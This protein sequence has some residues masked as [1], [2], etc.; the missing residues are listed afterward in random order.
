MT[1]FLD[2]D[3]VLHREPCLGENAFYRL[4][5]IEQILQDFPQV[6]IVVTSAW[7]LDWTTEA[8]AVAGLREHFSPS[9]RDRLVGATPDFREVDP[10]TAPDGLGAYLREWECMD[11]LRKNRPAGTPYL[12]LDNRHWWFRPN[13]PHLM[14]VDGDDGFLPENESEFRARLKASAGK[15]TNPQNTST[16]GG[17]S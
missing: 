11:W 13:N 8:E 2:F 5:L 17:S 15:P 1:L 16:N 10:T 6:Q 9:L 12:T 14:I 4:P 7:R 3:G